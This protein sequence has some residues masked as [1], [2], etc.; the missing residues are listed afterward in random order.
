MLKLPDVGER[1]SGE[2]AELIGNTP[3]QFAAYVRS[4]I[5][6]WSRVVRLSGAWPD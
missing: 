4:E 1:L 2:G 6:K 3:V 5:D